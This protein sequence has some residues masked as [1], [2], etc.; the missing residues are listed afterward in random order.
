MYQ[1]RIDKDDEDMTDEA[2]EVEFSRIIPLARLSKEGEEYHIEATV[3]ECAALTQ[4][5]DLISLEGLHA[6]VTI[7]SF[8]K[9]GGVRFSG[10]FE[11]NV[12]QSCVITNEPVATHLRKSFNLLFEPRGEEVEK[13]SGVELVLSFEVEE[14]E[15][16]EGDELDMGEC[17]VQ[18]LYLA[19][20]PYLRKSDAQV[21]QK[22]K[23]KLAGNLPG[24]TDTDVDI[25]VDS[26]AGK[27][28]IAE[29]PFRLS[30]T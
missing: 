11:A 19:L 20:D 1:K 23:K 30:R 14:A 15:P 25:D 8:G 13:N 3:R 4:R 17:I 26:R 18:Y 28:E 24:S 2:A 5:F 29:G 9:R 22:L 10:T 7:R 21:P 6:D 16:L 12:V 27:A